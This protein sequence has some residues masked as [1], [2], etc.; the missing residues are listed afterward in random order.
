MFLWMTRNLPRP[1][2]HHR[3]CNNRGHRHQARSRRQIK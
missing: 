1:R 3:K 2:R